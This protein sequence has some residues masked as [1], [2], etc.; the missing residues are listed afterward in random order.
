MCSSNIW[1]NSEAFSWGPLT[2]NNTLLIMGLR[3]SSLVALW[4]QKYEIDRLGAHTQWSK[5]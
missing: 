3:T 2:S 1:F 5:R 4:N